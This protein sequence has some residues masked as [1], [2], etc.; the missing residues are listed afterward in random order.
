VE[1]AS[2]A[3]V[4]ASDVDRVRGAADVGAEA[5][6]ADVTEAE[7]EVRIEHAE[8]DVRA[9]FAAER[10]E[11]IVAEEAEATANAEREEDEAR[12][13]AGADDPAARARVDEA[14]GERGTIDVERLEA[15]LLEAPFDVEPEPL[16]AAARVLLL[17]LIE[18]LLGLSIR[19]DGALRPL[20]AGRGRQRR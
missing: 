4:P 3:P 12:A 17:R 15:E 5:A 9:D 6:E 18:L 7:I 20:R 11:L 1:A 8:R 16:E 13:D 10:V 14:G 2:D 19:V